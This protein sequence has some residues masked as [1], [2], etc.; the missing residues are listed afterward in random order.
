MGMSGEEGGW[1]VEESSGVAVVEEV[2]RVDAGDES[3]E[4]V[5]GRGWGDGEK[6]SSLSWRH[7]GKMDREVE[8][9]SR[10]EE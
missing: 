2:G 6:S 3:T 1:L 9:Q 4:G 10:M 8:Q 5:C 7:E